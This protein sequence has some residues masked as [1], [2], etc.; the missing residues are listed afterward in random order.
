MVG[1]GYLGTP[2]AIEQ[3]PALYLP[4]PVPPVSIS[5]IGRA[6]LKASPPELSPIGHRSVG[7]VSP[8]G[9]PPGVREARAMVTIW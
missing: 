6:R 1:A 5:P 8:Q 2:R 7:A 4:H 9:C 3:L